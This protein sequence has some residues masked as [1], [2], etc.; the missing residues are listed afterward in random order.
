MAT[1]ATAKASNM[2]NSTVITV[3]VMAATLMQ[4]LDTTIVN[5]AMP[6]IQGSL[7]A[8]PDQ[9]TWILTSYIVAAAIMTP[10]VSWLSAHFGR[11]N[12][13]LVSVAGFTLA[14]MLCGAAESLAEIV[15]FRAVQGVFGAALVPLSQATMLDIFPPAQRGQAMAI[16]VM[17][18]V[19]G[20]IL[21][22]TLG[23]YLTDFYNWRWV[24]YI[25]LP[26]G[27]LALAGLWYFLRDTGRNAQLHFDFIGFS[28][29]SLG[30]GALQLMLDRGEFK[31]WFGSTEIIVY[32]VFCGLGFYL[33]LVHLF[34]A[35]APL[36][37]P[38]I[39]RDMNFSA[40]LAMIFA[41]GMIILAT[42]A[43][44]APYLQVLAG[45]S[46]VDTGILLAPRG[47]GTMAAVILAGRLS[48]R[49]DPRLLMFIGILLISESLWEMTG[50]T[51]DIDAWS[52]TRNAIIQGFGLGLVFTPLQVI[53]FSTL[54]SEMGT[55]G[56][57]L[58]SLLRNVGLAIGVSVTS[59]VLTRSTQFMH[60]QIV[61]NVSS[62]NRNLQVGGAYLW[63]SPSVPQGIAALNAEVT[64]QAAIIG[65]VNDFKLLF[66][67]SLLM[68]PLLL[69]MSWSKETARAVGPSA[70]EANGRSAS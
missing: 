28:A 6:Y 65:Y 14:S 3:C 44:L 30:L 11:K 25:N 35:K 46:V 22:P 45:R 47:I 42:S 62:F 4:T 60:A 38:R 33:F 36:I 56:T 51:P 48:D 41:I 5:V 8:S 37:P 21:G 58:F 50:W 17:G 10:P 61:D 31:D 55:D 57:A 9:I 24:F 1:P 70:V 13:F 23:G 49:V 40:G 20:P 64:R 18:V 2:A 19:M 59:V 39:F 67:V 54:P 43:L 32:A 68:L 12:L 63:W 52:L 69:M 15:L 34:T 27:I 29:L 7:A 26:F 66:I 16:W 53:A